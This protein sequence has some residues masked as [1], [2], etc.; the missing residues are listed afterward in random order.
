[1][2]LK[3]WNLFLSI[4]FF[5]L[6]T[7]TINVNAISTGFST[8]EISP[9]ER[10]LFMSNIDISLLTKEPAKKSVKCFDVNQNRKIAICHNGIYGDEVCVYSDEGIFLYGYSFNCSQSYAIEWDNENINIYFVRSDVIISLDSDG[11]VLD[12]KKV[13]DTIDNNTHSN[14]LLHSN[15]RVVGDTM[16]II[17]NDMKIFNY[18]SSSYSQII[19]V[20]AD[21]IEN[22]IYDVGST[23]AINKM[24]I[25]LIS[26]LVVLLSIT[27]VIYKVQPSKDQSNKTGDSK[28]GDGSVSRS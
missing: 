1:M 23:H 24:V 4:V 14:T 27:I 18:I 11:V 6:L 13:E 9:E 19:A 12:V 16:Y 8:A 25:L 7:S 3:R 10:D 17:K 2:K 5:L 15:R 22:I 21:G 28:T 26:F 20:D